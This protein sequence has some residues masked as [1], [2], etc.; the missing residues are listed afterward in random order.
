MKKGSITVEAALVLPIF[1]CIVISVMFFIRVVYTHE[2]IQHAIAETAKEMASAGYI[3]HVSGLGDI[4]AKLDGGMENRAQIFK[5][6]VNTVF[7]S[8]ESLGGLLD[9]SRIFEAV[10]SNPVNELKNAVCMISGGIYEDL[11]TQLF[12]P[13]VKLN[14]MK[15]LTSGS[16]QN[17]DSRLRALNVQ[18]GFDGLNLKGS[19][20][21]ADE[22]DE[23]DIVVKYKI[24]LPVPMKILPEFEMV[25]RAS[26]KAWMGGDKASALIQGGNEE[27]IWALDNFTR[28][29]RIRSVF[30]AN[31]P[32]SFPVIAKFSSGEATMIKSMDL[33]ADSYKSS[34]AMTETLDEYLSALYAYRGQEEPWGSNKT[35]IRAQEIK[36]KEL[37]LVIPKNQLNPK[38]EQLLAAFAGKASSLGIKL[39]IERYGLKNTV[40]QN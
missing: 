15:Y 31:L 26:V 2:L 37:L 5:D 13:L 16:N 4:N 25:Q 32:F 9:S 3:F 19:S 30:G 1:L 28:G 10:T 7:E 39:V 27:D 38:T 18:G 21:L 20:F 33:T 23:I 29:K 6:H 17:A 34:I 14:M 12:T 40:P 35:V 11:K 8:F 22:N 24:N 36:R